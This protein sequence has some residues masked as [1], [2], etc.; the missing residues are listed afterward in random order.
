MQGIAVLDWNE[1]YPDCRRAKRRWGLL[2]F[3]GT[4]LF[5]G[6]DLGSKSNGEGAA[7]N[8]DTQISRQL[9]APPPTSTSPPSS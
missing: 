6:C 2:L 4:C 9:E 8:A 3:S 7:L 5:L 1:P